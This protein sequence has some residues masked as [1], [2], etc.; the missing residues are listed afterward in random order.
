MK[1]EKIKIKNCIVVNFFYLNNNKKLLMWCK[2]WKKLQCFEI[3]VK[4]KKKKNVN[5]GWKEVG[6]EEGPVEVAKRGNISHKTE[7]GNRI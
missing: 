2:K 3:N 7:S 6:K 4:K 5:E 1:S